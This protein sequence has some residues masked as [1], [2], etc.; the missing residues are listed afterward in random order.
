MSL[1]ARVR[2]NCIQDRK[3]KPHPFPKRLG[4][5]PTGEP[6]IGEGASAGEHA[7]WLEDSC[8]HGGGARNL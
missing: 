7:S 4:F 6:M 5:D 8:E 1:D 2:C 3:A